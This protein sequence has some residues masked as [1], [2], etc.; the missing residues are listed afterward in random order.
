[1]IPFS[2]CHS[3]NIYVEQYFL[4]EIII[5]NTKILQYNIYMYNNR[6]DNTDHSL[7]MNSTT[8]SFLIVCVLVRDHQF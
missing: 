5:C 2:V 8:S 6:G 4:F 1:M 3:F 7:S